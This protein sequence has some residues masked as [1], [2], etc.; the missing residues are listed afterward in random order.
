MTGPTWINHPAY[1]VAAFDV[2]FTPKSRGGRRYQRRHVVVFAGDHVYHAFLT[3]LAGH[4][5]ESRAAF[6]RVLDSLREEA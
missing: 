3:C 2:V 6:E 1:R 4:N 5:D